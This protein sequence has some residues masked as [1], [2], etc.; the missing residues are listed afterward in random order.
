MGFENINM[1]ANFNILFVDD[2]E[3]I[4]KALRRLFLEEDF[5]VYTAKSGKEG[6]EIIQDKEFAVIVSDQRMPE[7][8]GTEFLLRAKELS[9]NTLRIILTGYAD[10]N[11]AMDA[12]NE[13]GAYRYITKPWND[14]ELVHIIKEAVNRY[15][16]IK[17]NIFLSELTKKQKEQLEAWSKELEYYVQIHTIDLTKKDK[18][19]KSLKE[20]LTNNKKELMELFDEILALRAKAL[21]NHSKRVEL[22]AVEMAKKLSL[23]TAEVAMISVAGNLHDIG[24]IGTSDMLLFKEPQELSSDE[25]KQYIKHPILGQRAVKVVSDLQ[26]VALLI[27]HHHE[28]FDGSG[29]PDNLKRGKIPLGSRILSIADRFERISRSRDIDEAFKIIWHSL[30]KEFDSELF[31]YLESAVQELKFSLFSSEDIIEAEISIN[32]LEPGFIV[33]KDVYGLSGLLIIKKDTVLSEKTIDL[34]KSA[35]NHTTAKGAISVY[36]K[37]KGFQLN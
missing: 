32:D 20:K 29:F 24:K 9:P 5:N 8:T 35:F 36:K 7:M 2:E 31:I 30:N 19:L 4:L 16:L 14:R 23:T 21:F 10:I 33:A 34:L 18:E 27:R 6:L 26:D 13:A 22:I 15:R 1:E 3:N 25:F 17:E 28:N 37:R 11:A 12:I